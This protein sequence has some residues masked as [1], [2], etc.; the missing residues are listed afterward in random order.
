MRMVTDDHR[1]VT[2]DD[3]CIDLPVSSSH[4]GVDPSVNTDKASQ[5]DQVCEAA[6]T[7]P[8]VFLLAL[9]DDDVLVCLLL[10]PSF[11]HSFCLPLTKVRG[12]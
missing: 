7:C 12:T 1:R 11:L 3:V 2:G 9:I 5:T 10:L 4:E 6:A 8:R